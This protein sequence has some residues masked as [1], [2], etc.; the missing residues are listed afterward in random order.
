MLYNG[1]SAVVCDEHVTQNIRP[2]YNENYYC[3]ILSI[4]GRMCVWFENGCLT[5][6]SKATTTKKEVDIIL[7]IWWW[8]YIDV[9]VCECER[10]CER[11]RAR[12]R[13]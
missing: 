8:A 9:Y 6:L 5:S 13:K 3:I 12:E 2:F 1:Q 7:K 4:R 10:E 11:E